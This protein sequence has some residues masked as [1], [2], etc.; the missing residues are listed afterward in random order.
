MR[1]ENCP[2]L[3]TEGYE[4]PESYCSV[5][6]ENDPLMCEFEDGKCGCTHPLNAIKKRIDANE[7][8]EAHMYDG[9]EEFY[10]EEQKKEQTA[11][12]I[13]LDVLNEKECVIAHKDLKGNLVKIDQSIFDNSDQSLRCDS[14][15][16]NIVTDFLYK[17][18]EKGY[19]IEKKE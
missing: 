13:L 15:T 12:N 11:L 10:I 16:R 6:S 17:M 4:Y 14:L 18:E 3:R 8:A 1:C 5:Y 2:A 7:K 19:R 9:I